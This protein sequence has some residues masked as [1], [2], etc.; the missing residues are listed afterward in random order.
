M[1][2]LENKLTSSDSRTVVNQPDQKV[3][4]KVPWETT[5][6]CTLLTVSPDGVV[7]LRDVRGYVRHS[8]VIKPIDPYSRV[9]L[10]YL[11]IQVMKCSSH[12]LE[13]TRLMRKLL[14]ELR[15]LHPH[16]RLIKMGKSDD[17]LK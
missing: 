2:G 13:R 16:P 7:D 1:T 11:S 6:G 8:G 14:F 3:H 5:Q 15:Q 10:N 17:T 12:M 9:P 4:W